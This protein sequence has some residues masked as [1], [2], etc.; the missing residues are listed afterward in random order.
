M[1][2]TT[3][4][5]IAVIIFGAILVVLTARSAKQMQIQCNKEKTKMDSLYIEAQAYLDRSEFDSTWECLKNFNPSVIKCRNKPAVYYYLESLK[6]QIFDYRE[7]FSKEFLEKTLRDMEVDDYKLLCKKQLE[8]TYFNPEKVNEYFLELLYKERLNRNRYIAEEKT[9]EAKRK[10]EVV[11]T[12]AL[13]RKQYQNQLRNSFL[14]N[15]F[16]INVHVTGADN[17]RLIL[18]Y[19]LF[20]DVWF[21]KMETNGSFDNWHEMGFNRVD[22]KDGYKYHKYMYWR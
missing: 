14:D 4:F 21:R 8:K 10:K 2:K 7:R 9:R 20:N 22:I 3:Y 19:P 16:D 15:G 12:A 5:F 18:I 1:K 11:R 17:K 6:K 13:K